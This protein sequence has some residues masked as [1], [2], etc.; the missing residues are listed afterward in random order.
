MDE[1]P[2]RVG[3]TARASRISLTVVPAPAEEHGEPTETRP[4]CAAC[5]RC[6]RGRRCSAPALTITMID[7]NAVEADGLA[8]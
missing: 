1:N 2:Q 7:P 5:R 6:C 3:D 4:A 8:A